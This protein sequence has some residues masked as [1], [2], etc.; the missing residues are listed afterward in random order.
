[1][2]ERWQEGAEEGRMLAF[3][4]LQKMQI[5][6]TKKLH[7]SVRSV[8]SRGMIPPSGGGGREFESRNG[9]EKDFLP[10]YSVTQSTPSQAV[11]CTSNTSIFC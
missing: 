1:M 7:L 9:P 4:N 2:A 11:P 8:W 5:I 6:C 3:S 10:F